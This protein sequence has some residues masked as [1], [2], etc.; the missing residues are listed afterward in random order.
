MEQAE[1]QEASGDGAVQT[2]LQVVLRL[3]GAAI[4]VLSLLLYHQLQASWWLFALLFLVPD[5]SFLGYLANARI[6][7]LAYNCA[8]S[9]VGPVS[10]AVLSQ[11]TG[12]HE[13][14]PFAVIW[15]AHVGFDRMLGYGLKYGRGFGYTHLGRIGPAAR[16]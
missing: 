4:M 15:T 14:M 6:G 13:L 8:H 1:L 12:N 2:P 11:W 16:V 10:L 9:L 5:L 7:A 3:E